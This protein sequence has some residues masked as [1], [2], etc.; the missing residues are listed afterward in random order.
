[1]SD[2]SNSNTATKI[3][4]SENKLSNILTKCEVTL[5]GQAWIDHSLDLFKDS[6]GRPP[7]VGY[8]DAS[9]RIIVVQKYTSTTSISRPSTVPVGSSWDC[10]IVNKQTNNMLGVNSNLRLGFNSFMSDNP[11]TGVNYG[12]VMVFSG[13]AGGVMGAD[14]VQNANQ[15]T[16]P[17][18]FWG[19]TNSSRCI[20]KA[21]EV[22]NT[23]A[24]L[25]Q[26]GS[27]LVYQKPMTSPEKTLF[28]FVQQSATDVLV[29]GPLLS[30]HDEDG[31]GTPAQLLNLP[32]ARIWS[33]KEGVYQTCTYCSPDNPAGID[34]PIAMV[35]D[36]GKRGAN[37]PMIT[38][39][40]VIPPQVGN[41][42]K[43]VSIAEAN[44]PFIS[45]FD[46]SGCYFQGLS[47]ETTLQLTAS[48]LLENSP[49]RT[50]L[51]LNTL[52]HP[53]PGLDNCALEIYSKMVHSLP[54]GV[55]V[56]DNSAGDWINMIADAAAMVGVPG[57]GLIKTG[58]KLLSNA[59]A[60]YKSDFGKMTMP[61]QNSNNGK[62]TLKR[63]KT[64]I[65]KPTQKT[66][67]IVVR[68]PNFNSIRPMPNLPSIPKK[69]GK[70]KNK[71]KKNIKRKIPTQ[72]YYV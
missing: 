22:V 60:F 51:S 48:W 19:G 37:F 69:K 40:T 38:A 36:D 21:H 24:V 64:K 57:A 35:W 63:N 33:A 68:Q 7:C 31:L 66:S 55:P 18:S 65:N 47:S 13:P 34:R 61:N 41:P 30:Y 52:S 11:L 2:S 59:I 4:R 58:G 72:V 26:Q 29:Y 5:A 28:T 46:E 67:A 8:P 1:M 32:K 62:Q 50:D 70:N 23:T 15:L 6:K 54:A 16:V 25:N 44:N 20:G 56:K 12:G 14:T 71:S 9:N 53:S 45:P 49:A 39:Y 43:A 17:Q 3:D 42:V 27:V 10:H